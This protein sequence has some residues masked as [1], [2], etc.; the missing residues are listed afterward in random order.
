M[1]QGVAN[2]LAWD[3]GPELTERELEVCRLVAL[4][5]ST[6]ETAAELGLSTR[7]VESYRSRL[8]TKLGV[9][10]RRE[11]VAFALRKRLIP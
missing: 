6:R 3:D 1:S 11:L 4:G 7:T 10:S 5:Y 2:T 8:N 9:K